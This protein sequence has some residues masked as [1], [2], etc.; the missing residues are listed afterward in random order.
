MVILLKFNKN[1]VLNGRWSWIHNF[2]I[3]LQV[4]YV[5]TQ[6]VSLA[7]IVKFIQFNYFI[8]QPKSLCFANK[9]WFVY[10]NTGTGRSVDA[11]FDLIFTRAMNVQLQMQRLYCNGMEWLSSYFQ[12]LTVSCWIIEVISVG[13]MAH[14]LGPALTQYKSLLL[15]LASVC[16]Y[17]EVFHTASILV[18]LQL[19]FLE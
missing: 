3:V 16:V 7:T 4:Y 17:F 19:S 9:I 8:L 15:I 18:S 6:R 13:V 11:A 10:K 12:V 2:V 1:H 14:A 5:I